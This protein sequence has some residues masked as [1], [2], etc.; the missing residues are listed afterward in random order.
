MNKF[1]IQLSIRSETLAH[2]AVTP[3]SLFFHTSDRGAF[4]AMLARPSETAGPAY[5]YVYVSRDYHPLA[6][7]MA[8][9]TC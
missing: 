3:Y 9:T 7:S 4:S 8:T 1:D 5:V 6:H 2:T